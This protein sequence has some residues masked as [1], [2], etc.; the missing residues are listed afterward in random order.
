MLKQPSR[1]PNSRGSKN[2]LDPNAQLV[3]KF[4]ALYASYQNPYTNP[5]AKQGA[6][7]AFRKD[8]EIYTK[9][10]EAAK[11][12]QGEFDFLNKASQTEAVT[13]YKNEYSKAISGIAMTP[14]KYF[15]SV[16]LGATTASAPVYAPDKGDDSAAARVFATMML[17][18]R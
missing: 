12:K 5:E 13:Q 7:S 11:I 18:R 10:A 4:K 8:F 1:D 9:L 14:S 2:I 3:K 17:T 16:G 15:E 6:I